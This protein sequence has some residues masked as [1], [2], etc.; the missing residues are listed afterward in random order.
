MQSLPGEVTRLIDEYRRGDRAAL[1]QDPATRLRRAAQDRAP[2]TCAASVRPH[3]AADRARHEAYLRLVDQQ[4]VHVAEPRPLPRRRRAGDAPHPGRPR[5]RAAAR[6]ARRRRRARHARRRAASPPL[7]RDLDARG[8]RRRA[9]RPCGALDAR[10][11]AGRRAALLR[12]APIEERPRCSALDGDRSS[13]TWAT[14]RS[15][16]AARAAR[17]EP[18]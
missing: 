1:D 3:A 13:A 17:E 5:A 9:R 4:R 15:V 14:A 10:A 7:D 12:R 11:G 18:A 16:A 6:E 2:R 8:A